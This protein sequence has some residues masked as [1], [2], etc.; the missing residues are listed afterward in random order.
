MQGLSPAC[1]I[2]AEHMLQ[3]QPRGAEELVPL[4]HTG[5]L[6]PPSAAQASFGLCCLPFSSLVSFFLICPEFV[7]APPR[8]HHS[9]D[10]LMQQ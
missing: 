6:G 3:M 10:D 8:L 2:A 1:P 5:R 7:A 4:T 9:N